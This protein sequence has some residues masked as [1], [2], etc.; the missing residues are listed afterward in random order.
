MTIVASTSPIPSIC[1]TTD[2]SV[3]LLRHH[4]SPI[5]ASTR[6]RGPSSIASIHL[7]AP[8]IDR[9]ED[10]RSNKIL[11]VLV[12]QFTGPSVKTSKVCRHK[13]EVSTR[14]DFSLHLLELLRHFGNLELFMHH[15]EDVL[16]D[17]GFQREIEQHAFP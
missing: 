14:R 17:Q 1:F 6:Q 8:A 13:T 4:P 10:Q 11:R 3:G 7:W 15:P 12:D 9:K 16:T 2:L 5:A